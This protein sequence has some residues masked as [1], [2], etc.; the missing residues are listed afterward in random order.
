ML[1]TYILE[2][3]FLLSKS[4]RQKIIE[5]VLTKLVYVLTFFVE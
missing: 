2:K 5:S 3:E 4:Y 1:V